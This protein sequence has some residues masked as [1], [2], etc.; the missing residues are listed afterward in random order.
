MFLKEQWLLI[1][2]GFPFVFL[3]PLGDLIVPAY[4]GMVIQA[5]VDGTPDQL[6]GL[7]RDWG[8]LLAAG[9]VAKL[10]QTLLYGRACER[11]G[12]SVRAKLFDS[13]IRKDLTYF[14]ETK[15]GDISK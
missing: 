13:T 5:M 6:M 7:I 3:A 14:D 12:Y 8:I 4:I 9:C 11:I 2:I 15:T 1:T 10:I